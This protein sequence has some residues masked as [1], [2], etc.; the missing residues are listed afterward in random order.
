MRNVMF[1]SPKVSECET[2]PIQIV[3]HIYS[4]PIQTGGGSHYV[5]C[6]IDT[7]RGWP[8]QHP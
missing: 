8:Y 7:Q 4:S 5:L 2:S 3:L 1:D 6:G